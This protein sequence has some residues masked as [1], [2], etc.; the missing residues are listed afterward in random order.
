MSAKRIIIS[1]VVIWIVSSLFG[2]LTCGWLFKWVY[3]LPPNI[4]KDPVIMMSAGNMIGMNVTGLIGAL[5]FALVFAVL[6][7]GIPGK[8]VA[9]GMMYG[10]LVWLVGALTGIGSMPFYMTI[11]TTVVVYWLINALVLSVINGAVVGAIYKE[12]KAKTS[13]KARKSR[14]TR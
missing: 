5:L 4:W 11:A 3:T 8:G 7:K 9:K 6:Y 1:G 14:K 12:K 13:R 10:I 2:W